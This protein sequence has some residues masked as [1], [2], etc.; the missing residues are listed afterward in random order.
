MRIMWH[1]EMLLFS[2]WLDR[3]E[4]NT[5][6]TPSDESREPRQKSYTANPETQTK[7]VIFPSFPPT[8]STNHPP[9]AIFREPAGAASPTAHEER[10]TSL[11]QLVHPSHLQSNLEPR[12]STPEQRT[13]LSA[14]I[15]QDSS[16]YRTKVS[17]ERRQVDFIKSLF[18]SESLRLE[19]TDTDHWRTSTP[20]TAPTP[21]DPKAR[22]RRG[23]YV[24]TPSL[25]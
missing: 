10:P 21:L 13:Y 7:N 3:S 20:C 17:A 25:A 8:P 19:H 6:F 1:L 11:T 4:W 5:K 22:T 24:P 14:S 18:D 23:R 2:G 16:G 15:A 9:F 12:P